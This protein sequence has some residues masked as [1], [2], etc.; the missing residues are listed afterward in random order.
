MKALILSTHLMGSGHLVRAAALARGVH[1]AGGE[2][3]LINGG[4]PIPYLDLAGLEVLQL[5]PVASDGL[6]YKVLLNADG[7]RADK[8]QLDERRS[9]ILSAFDRFQPDAVITELFPFGRRMLAAEF[10]ALIAHARAADPRPAILCSVRDAPEPPKSTGRTEE[11]ESRLARFYDAVLVHGDAADGMFEAA[12]PVTDAI[13]PMLRYTGYIADPPPPAAP[14]GPGAGEVLVSVGGGVVGRR[15]LSTA[16]K[17]AAL[18]NRRWR[19][20]V[21]GADAGAAVLALK[22]EAGGDVA[23]EPA[24]PDYRELLQRAA[25]SISLCGYNTALDLRQSGAP[26]V[27]VPIEQAGEREQLIRAESLARQKQFTLLRETEATPEALAEAVE[28]A[29]SAGPAAPIQ[30]RG[31]QRSAEI[32]AEEIAKLRAAQE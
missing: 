26:A 1:A 8:S 27:L 5:A 19:L 20:L 7:A 15:L 22:A 2:A 13:R 24:R 16:V 21:G 18:S 6:N 23:I 31:A 25:C 10:E 28:A 14:D 17:A 32:I 9:I 30:P 11:S 12:W 3:L 4:R 29:I